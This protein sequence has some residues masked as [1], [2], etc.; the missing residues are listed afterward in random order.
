[1]IPNT[2]REAVL[3]AMERFDREL[4]DSPEWS[5]WEQKESHK[6]AIEQGGRRYPVKKI[7]SNAPVGSFSG[8]DEANTYMGKLG[9]PAVALR[10]SAQAEASIQSLLEQVL[11]QYLAARSGGGFGAN[12][13]IWKVFI[14]LK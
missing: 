12:H 8:G 9:F 2:T 1:M 14:R 7:V 4:R 3:E 13:P 6:Y 11:S 5:S 10:Q